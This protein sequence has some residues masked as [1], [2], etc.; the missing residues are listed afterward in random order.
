MRIFLVDHFRPPWCGVD[1][2]MPARLIAFSTHVD[3]Q[4]LQTPTSQG[5]PLLRKFVG[6][7]VHR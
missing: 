2:T 6:E 3:L 5:Q 4:R 7:N 1:V